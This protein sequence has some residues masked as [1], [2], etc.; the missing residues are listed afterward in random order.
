LI[1]PTYLTDKPGNKIELKQDDFKVTSN[2]DPIV[3]KISPS[4]KAYGSYQGWVLVRTGETLLT[5]FSI[6]AETQPLIMVATLW[7][8]IGIFLSLTL[9]ELIKYVK[10]K[11]AECKENDLQIEAQSVTAEVTSLRSV[12]FGPIYTSEVDRLNAIAFKKMQES[13]LWGQVAV[14]L[15]ERWSKW[16]SLV[17]I[18]ILQF[19]S[20]AFGIAIG[21]L[22]IY[23]N[24]AVT[25]LLVIGVQEILI[26]LG[27]GLGIG[28]LK[29][30]VDKTA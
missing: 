25:N 24:T 3:L 16:R 30:L 14:G 27:L 13:A 15:K 26:L 10:R 17:K 22:G 19:G 21:F 4:S 29:E 7:V 12:R 18:I 28:S 8:L 5:S 2:A 20:I 11:E 6:T 1:L 9:W 23:N